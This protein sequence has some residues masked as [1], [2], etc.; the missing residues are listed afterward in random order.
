MLHEAGYDKIELFSATKG[1]N[2]NVSRDIIPQE[3]SYYIENVMPES[4][5]EGEIRYGTSTFSNAPTDKVIEAFSFTSDTGA[6]QQVL[7]LYGYQN[8]AGSTNLRVIS[9]NQIELTNV[10]YA[11]FVPDTYLQLVYRDKYGTSSPS[12]YEIKNITSVNGHPNTIILEVQQNSFSDSLQDFYINA[13]GTPNPQYISPTEFSISIPS[14]F[15]TSLYYNLGASIRLTINNIPRN[16]I[17]SEI[18]SIIPGELIFSTIGD[19]IPAFTGADTVSLSYQSSTPDI[20]SISN[21]QGYIKVLDVATNTLLP[22]VNQTLS[23]LSV[24]CV[25]RSEFFDKRLWI[26]NG[27]DD[28]MTWDGQTLAVYEEIVKENANSFN[29]ID[30]R[31][32]SFVSDAAFNISKYPVGGSVYLSVLNVGSQQY[33]ISAINK[34]GNVVT[35]TVTED[36]IS[37]TG[38]NRISLFYFDKLPK[39]N[40]M[41]SAHDRLWCLGQGA[42]SLDYRIPEESMRI[43]YSYRPVGDD[44]EPF[45]FFNEQT[46]TVPSMDISAKH[47]EADNL[48][49]IAEHGGK[50]A[51]IGRKKSQVWAGIDPLTQGSSDYFSWVQNL[52]IGIYHGNLLIDLPNDVWVLSPNGFSSAS[53]L[54][55]AKQFAVSNVSNMD[56]VAKEYINSINSNIQY[57]ACRSFK[58]DLGGFCGFK[59]GLNNIIVSK[60]HSSLY[61]WCLFTGDFRSSTTFLSGPNDSL[62]IYVNNNIYTYADGSNGRPTVYGDRDGTRYINYVEIKYVNNIKK[63]YSNKR[64]DIDCEYSSNVIINKENSLN[65]YISGDL[66]ETFRLRDRYDLPLKG[67]VLGTIPLVKQDK[68]GNDPNYPDKNALGFR[69]GSPIRS[70]KGRLQFLSNRF[71]VMIVGNLKDGPFKIKR[72]RLLGIVER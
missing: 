4:L 32:F 59:I 42:V 72:I 2:Q 15:I 61:W 41:K 45:R 37:F 67:D 33:E 23:G 18:D 25:P 43:Y 30:N 47:G 20:S 29:R 12:L 14:D 63:R 60:F 65:V 49:A 54:N 3:Y 35:I 50:L 71:S 46:K 58:Y 10:N 7:Y 40:Y 24:A 66:R 11:L 28:I 64:Y 31:N 62:Y 36:L 56:K 27:V 53:S 34:V 9:A 16:L 39:F 52:E 6:K 22:G 68:A 8:F 55:A 57:R 5:G 69:L 13:P 26:C 19:S 48:E 21:S 51:F 1:M 44:A 70:L 17:I 38:V